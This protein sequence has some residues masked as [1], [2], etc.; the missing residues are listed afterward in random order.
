MPIFATKKAIQLI[1]SWNHFDQVHEVARLQ[2]TLIGDHFHKYLCLRG[3]GVR[4]PY[5]DIVLRHSSSVP[6]P[7]SFCRCFVNAHREIRANIT[8]QTGNSFKAHHKSDA[9]YYHSAIV[10]CFENIDTP[11]GVEAVIYT[12]YGVQAESFTAMISSKTTVQPLHGLHDVS[13]PL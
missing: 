6:L 10:I 1:R 5:R 12:P 3:L 9:L 2:V 4:I 7:W 11:K 13:I 8:D